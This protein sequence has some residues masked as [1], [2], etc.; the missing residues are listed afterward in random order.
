MLSE[1]REL[2]QIRAWL[3]GPKV[4]PKVKT[5]FEA[6]ELIQH[7]LPIRA[8]LAL[9]ENLGTLHAEFALACL[10]MSPRT[11]H[12]K[13]QEPTKMLNQEQ[14][15][16]T[17]KFAELLARATEIFGSKQAAEDWLQRPAIGLDGRRPI[18]LLTTPTGMQLVEDF[19]TRIEYGVYT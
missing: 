4:I 12:R 11:F 6:H 8:V 1:E 19:L 13:K 2:S 9:M 7:G 15:G 3:G 17:W 18:E 14:S 10:G 16:R 5:R